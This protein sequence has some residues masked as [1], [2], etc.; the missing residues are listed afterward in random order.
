MAQILDFNIALHHKQ[1]T[2]MV[3]DLVEYQDAKAERLNEIANYI[4]RHGGSAIKI[5]EVT[6]DGVYV[7]WLTDKQAVNGRCVQVAQGETI[8]SYTRAKEIFSGN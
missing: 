4:R 8:K 1:F 6:D 3:A 7:L 2:R 5:C